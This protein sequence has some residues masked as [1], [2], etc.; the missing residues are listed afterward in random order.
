MKL[1]DQG[2]LSFDYIL[3][4]YNWIY[5]VSGR[6]A[7]GI[8]TNQSHVVFERIDTSLVKSRAFYFHIPF[9]KSICSFCTFQRSPLQDD[10]SVEMYTRALIREIQ[11]KAKYDTVTSIP[12]EAIFIGGGSPSVLSPDQIR[13][14]G[15]AIHDQYDLS[16]LS[17]YSVE[18]SVTSITSDKLEA[19]RDIGV[20]HARFGIQTFNPKYRALF[21]LSPSLEPVYAAAESLPQYFPYT[22]FDMMYGFNGQ[23]E[24]EFVMDIERAIS[25]DI[26]NID[27]Y[28]INNVVT[29]IL[30]HSAYREAGLPPTSGLGRLL[31]NV[32]LREIMESV[33]YLPHN[34]QEYVKVSSQE[35]RRRPVLTDKYTFQYHQ[36]VYGYQD[37]EFIGFGS[38]AISSVN[39]YTMRNVS[40]WERYVYT[41]M[42]DNKC[43]F[44]VGEHDENFDASKG[45]ILHLPYH[46]YA[47]KG[48]IIFD[49]VHP[50]TLDALER[51]I[52]AGLVIERPDRYELTKNGW[53]WYNN[54]IYYLSPRPEQRILDLFI[55]KAYA[56]SD[57][58]IGKSEMPVLP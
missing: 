29:Q 46:G 45:I 27:F 36:H 1:V 49:S 9:C 13:R 22:S 38:S 16:R 51:L 3:P 20:T 39:R 53:F 2:L 6:P 23:T 37:T 15:A 56:D 12:V 17:E 7:E 44:S 4:I 43:E 25:L 50:E 57:R 14:I 5:P 26:P 41:L 55:S 18:L 48:R 54:L 10:K 28:S 30:L 35:L 58:Q 24:E 32:L 34:G 40:S 8:D 19:F 21:N 31:M 33:G 42:N 11:L 47:D 52:A